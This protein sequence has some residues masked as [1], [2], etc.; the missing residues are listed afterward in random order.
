LF[1][2]KFE[3]LIFA[4]SADFTVALND[5]HS[6]PST[7]MKQSFMRTGGLTSITKTHRHP[8]PNFRIAWREN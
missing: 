2:A 5:S 8:L 1:Y 6:P 3:Y 4:P 7:S